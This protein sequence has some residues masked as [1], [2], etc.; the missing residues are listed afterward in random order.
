MY[1]SE[2][3]VPA[4]SHRSRMWFQSGRSA[5]SHLRYC[6]DDGRI[7]GGRQ[8]TPALVTHQLRSKNPGSRWANPSRSSFAVSLASRHRWCRFW[9]R[10]GPCAWWCGSSCITRMRT[11]RCGSCAHVGSCELRLVSYHVTLGVSGSA[12]FGVLVA[13]VL[14]VVTL[15][16]WVALLDS[17]LVTCS[18]SCTAV[19]ITAL[20]AESGLI[21]CGCL[22]VVLMQP[23]VWLPLLR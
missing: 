4:A 11:F 16:G 21:L 19:W 17:C 18:L 9:R 15:R 8:P 20:L 23:V 7:V 22:G 1:R 10:S 5:P 3:A 12:G 6:A 14:F 13:R 2:A